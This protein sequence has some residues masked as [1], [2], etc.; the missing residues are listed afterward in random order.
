MSSDKEEIERELAESDGLRP[1]ES[2]GP[3]ESDASPKRCEFHQGERTTGVGDDSSFEPNDSLHD[4]FP[5]EPIPVVMGADGLPSII[6]PDPEDTQAIPYTYE[7]QLCIEDD[8]GYVEIFR[9]ELIARGW[10]RNDG[11][12]QNEEWRTSDGEKLILDLRSRFEQDG[13]DT[14]R[15]EFKPKAVSERWGVMLVGTADDPTA[16]HVWTP[17]RYKRERCEHLRQQVFSNDD[18]P[19]PAAFGHQ[20]VF[21]LC[22]ARRSNGGAFMSLNNEAIYSCDFRTPFD[23][24]STRLQR[25]KDK[26]KLVERPDLLKLPLFDMDG[27]AVQMENNA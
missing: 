6:T 17:V 18:I 19:D 15:R 4:A 24:P 5:I 3:S 22:A 21:R 20:I 23:V 2:E 11:H 9:E 27:D 14:K 7:T 26:K 8:R 13:T 1:D 16:G 12:G 10:R 25:S